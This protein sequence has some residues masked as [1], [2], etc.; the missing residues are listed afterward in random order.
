MILA[1][2]EWGLTGSPWHFLAI[3]AL[4]AVV[5]MALGLILRKMAPEV[6]S[7][8]LEAAMALLG[9]LIWPMTF[10]ALGF[11]LMV[12]STVGSMV[13]AF[14]WLGLVGRRYL[15]TSLSQD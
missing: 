8:K 14:S 1:L 9:F 7:G 12:F 4:Q 10:L 15:T 3:G 6:I 11:A 2:H 5:W 13:L